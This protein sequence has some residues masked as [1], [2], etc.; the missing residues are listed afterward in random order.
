VAYNDAR[1]TTVSREQA[2]IVQNSG[3]PS[4]YTIENLSRSNGT[5]VDGHKIGA[6]FPLRHGSTVKFGRSGPSFVFQMDP[7]PNV[8]VL[9]ATEAT[10]ALKDAEGEP[11]WARRRTM[12]DSESSS[13]PDPEPASRWNAATVS[14]IFAVVLLVAVLGAGVFVFAIRPKD[15]AS[16]LQTNGPAVVSIDVTWRL[17][18]P[19]SGRQAYHWHVP[20]PAAVNNDGPPGT[21]GGETRVPVFVRMPDGAIEPVLIL[22][23]ERDTNRPI[24]GRVLGSGC[25]IHENGFILTGSPVAAPFNGPYVWSSEALPA[26]LID[27][28]DH[29]V[30]QLTKLPAGWVPSGSRFVV[31]RRTGV[32]D[33]RMGR[34]ESTGRRLE[35]RL[36]AIVIGFSGSGNR[37]NAKLVGMSANNRIALLKADP[38]HSLRSVTIGETETHLSLA[39]RAYLIGYSL[40][41]AAPKKAA[42]RLGSVVT[43]GPA[44]AGCA[45]CYRISDSGTD[46]GFNGG[47]VFDDRGR[48]V[49]LFVTQGGEQATTFTVVPVGQAADLLGLS[50]K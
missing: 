36:D 32:E 33:V 40:A 37:I 21:T 19:E 4:L 50:R 6:P 11:W 22:D 47:P 3:D 8:T 13:A 39:D 42:V 14:L 30:S 31:T 23:D 27:P 18:D 46:A 24:A 5:F 16:I 45:G 29:T 49:G 2:R 12:A 48:L 25:I 1:D 35:G 20:R 44:T 41:G 43:P 34:V 15:S 26:L 10:N 9:E 28:G 38:L 7:P 17:F